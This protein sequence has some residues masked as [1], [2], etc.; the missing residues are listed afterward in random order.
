[1]LGITGRGER[2]ACAFHG[3]R[4]TMELEM[5]TAAQVGP[6]GGLI[7]QQE[8]RVP[9]WLCDTPRGPLVHPCLPLCT[10]L[11]VSPQV[12]IDRASHCELTWK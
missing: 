12:H 1:M 3:P 7:A 10:G 8:G 5:T 11:I 9:P 2:G 6:E 4:G